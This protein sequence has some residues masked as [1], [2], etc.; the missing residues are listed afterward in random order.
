MI[1]PLCLVTIIIIINNIII[2]SP[3]QSSV[4]LE[5]FLEA[6]YTGDLPQPGLELNITYTCEDLKLREFRVACQDH[7]KLPCIPEDV[8]FYFL[9]L[10]F[11]YAVTFS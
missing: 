8:S 1:I 7:Q 4:P 11:C 9:Q 5:H 6:L 2:R 10:Q 3:M